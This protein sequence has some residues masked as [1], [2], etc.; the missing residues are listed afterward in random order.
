MPQSWD[1]KLEYL[2]TEWECPL[3]VEGQARKLAERLEEELPDDEV[4]DRHPSKPN[5]YFPTVGR[6][7]YKVTKFIL[8]E[9]PECLSLFCDGKLDCGWGRILTEQLDRKVGT[10]P[11]ECYHLES[12]RNIVREGAKRLIDSLDPFEQITRW[13]ERGDW[14]DEI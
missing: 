14:K 11:G 13:L 6:I 12:A 7:N 1:R 4:W 8:N 5:P 9:L 10:W 3:D 2:P